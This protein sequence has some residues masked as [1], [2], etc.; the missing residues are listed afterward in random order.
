MERMH[1]AWFSALAALILV[2]CCLLYLSFKR[3]VH[4]YLLTV[5]AALPLMIVVGC[6]YFLRKLE[7]N[8][9]NKS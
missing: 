2:L 1:G 7:T 9:E 8:K 5:V 6:E 4:N 3:Y